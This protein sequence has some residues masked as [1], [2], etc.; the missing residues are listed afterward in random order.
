MSQLD[1]VSFDIDTGLYY[2]PNTSD[3]WIIRESY[4]HFVK[5][6]TKHD[7]VLDLGAHIGRVTTTV[8]P[9]VEHVTA[10]EAEPSNYELLQR[11]V[12]RLPN[13]TTRHGLV[14]KDGENPWLYRSVDHSKTA[15]H[16]A[17]P[18]YGY[19][20]VRVPSVGIS[21]LLEE[22]RPTAVKCDIEG[23]EFEV[24]TD[25]LLAS[26]HSLAVE[27]HLGKVAH[28]KAAPGLVDRIRASGLVPYNRVSF[29]AYVWVGFFVR[30]AGRA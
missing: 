29:R 19:Q 15:M 9:L 22:V 6:L 20:P 12:E 21:S 1:S 16:S 13:V 2:R 30:N 7:R 3:K 5:T 4:K 25:D 26:I 27:I 10:V 23:G 18:K 8:A 24:L 11:N 14:T 28:K 17:C